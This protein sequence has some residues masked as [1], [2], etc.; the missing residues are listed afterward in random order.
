MTVTGLM[1]R[2]RV[3]LVAGTELSYLH[4]P[5]FSLHDELALLVE[6]GLTPAEALRGATSSS[7]QIF[8]ALESGSIEPGKRADLVL[9]EANP[10]DDIRNTQRIYAVI[11]R[12]KLLDR[13]SFDG[14]LI[15]A[16]ELA[17]QN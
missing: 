8:P 4:P 13:K 6:A 12:G 3:T 7:A 2:L 1:N 14:L 16:A 5:G 17:L 15:R 11:L 10:L 9:L